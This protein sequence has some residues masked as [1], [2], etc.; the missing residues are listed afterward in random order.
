MY[1][2]PGWHVLGIC[3][4]LVI[5]LPAIAAPQRVVSTNL[6]ADEYV[7]RLMPRDRIAAL[8]FLSADRHPVVSTI[9]DRV[10]GIA[11]IYASTEEI[12]SA[13]PISS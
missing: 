6:C 12:F 8:S 9:V 1:R 3:A 11:L 13:I 4:A 2:F 10:Q 7:F 5:T